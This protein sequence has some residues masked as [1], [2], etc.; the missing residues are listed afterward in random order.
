M[1]LTESSLVEIL[2][3]AGRAD[4]SSGVALRDFH[5]LIASSPL[6]QLGGDFSAFCFSSSAAQPIIN[7]GIPAFSG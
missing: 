2:D 4:S 3:Y 1:G 5:V 6:V 7:T